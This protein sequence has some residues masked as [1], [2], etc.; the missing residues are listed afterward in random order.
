MQVTSQRAVGLRAARRGNNRRSCHFIVYIST[1]RTSGSAWYRRRVV[2]LSCTFQR[3]V[4]AALCGTDGGSFHFHYAVS[5]A[6]CGAGVCLC[7]FPLLKV[8]Y[9]AIY[10]KQGLVVGMTKQMS[11][12]K[13]VDIVNC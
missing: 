3:A 5:A 10:V 12:C 11:N 2:S 1:C 4:L 8:I 13:A 9:L 7:F 6:L